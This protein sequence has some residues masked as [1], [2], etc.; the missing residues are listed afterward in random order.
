M[1]VLIIDDHAIFREG[2][3]A[4]L[5]RERPGIRVT[6]A[7]TLTEG[8]APLEAKPRP[9]LVLLDLFLNTEGGQA[10]EPEAMLAKFAGFPVVILSGATDPAL[11]RR[12]IEA[13]AMGF[14]AK[15]MRYAE[16]SQ[17]LD[18]V[19]SGEVFLPEWAAAEAPHQAVTPTDPRL[20]A[21]EALTERQRQILRSVAYGWTNRT[22]AKELFIS[23]ETVKTHLANI[24]RELDVRSRTEA[25]YLLSQAKTALQLQ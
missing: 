18:R 1:H 9:S 5:G 7:G 24:F 14:I 25:V 2:L 8:L 13:G 12:C 21:I 15:T 11:V 20:R 6:E 17:A 23:E 16:F 4:L 10:N 22:I 3:V 19:L